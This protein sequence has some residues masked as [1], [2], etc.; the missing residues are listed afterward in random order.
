M[1]R[2]YSLA[3]PLLLATAAADAHD[4][5]GD[6]IPSSELLPEEGPTVET[7]MVF[8][9]GENHNFKTF[10]DELF[11]YNGECDL[12]L[13]NDPSFKRE[14]GMR[15]DIR[16][17]IHGSASGVTQAA[18]RIGDQVLEVAGGQGKEWIWVNGV[19]NED[20]EDGEWYLSSIDGLVVRLREDGDDREAV[21]YVDGYIEKLVFKANRA[22][23]FVHLDM[24][25]KGGK[26]SK[27][28]EGS[29]GLLGSHALNGLRVGRDGET[30]IQDINEFAQE[31]QVREDEDR[32]FHN[33]DDTMV[34]APSKCL[35]LSGNAAERRAL[36]SSK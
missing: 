18:V 33:Y 10:G 8:G 16:T 6:L 24:E 28:Y 32:L 23:D 9:T 35:L 1:V 12:I 17:Q 20:L 34:L 5:I 31:W 25:R 3:L 14:L 36:R 19:P 13:L 2:F 22:H 7:T 15:I 4:A 29:T 21:I 11:D 30:L 27:N 26:G